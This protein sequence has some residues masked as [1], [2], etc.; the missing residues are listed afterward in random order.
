[1]SVTP[2]PDRPGHDVKVNI[3][4]VEETTDKIPAELKK[5]FLS[6]LLLLVGFL[7]STTS[8]AF[9]HERVPDAAPL[10]DLVLDNL[11]YQPWALEVSE[12]I[13][14]V[15][16]LSATVVVLAHTHRSCQTIC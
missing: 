9:T 8:L 15:S 13:I 1:M 12:M 11:P 10:P 16:T 3:P 6:A 4:V 2:P 14:I 5:T 7:S